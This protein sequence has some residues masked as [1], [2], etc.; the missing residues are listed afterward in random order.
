[1]QLETFADP[2]AFLAA[3][4]PHLLEAEVENNLILG[5]A[6]GT[7][8]VGGG[9]E[10]PPYFSLVR[11]SGIQGCAFSTLPSKAGITRNPSREA[12][13]LLARDLLAARPQVLDIVGPEP[14]I[15]T[16]VEIFASLRGTRI[17]RR[18]AQRIHQCHA[19]EPVTP[20]PPGRYRVA[21][22]PDV[23]LLAG[24]LQEFMTEL[25]DPQGDPQEMASSRVAAGQLFL[26][27]NGGPVSMAGWT[28]RTA[29]GV[30]VG[31]VYTPA[32]F[33]GTGYATA[34]VTALTRQLLAEDLKYCCLYTDLANPTSNAIYARIGYR[35]VC[36]AAMYTISL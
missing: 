2:T 25:A 26:W 14:T 9:S 10:P 3:A 6:H 1:M 12:L 20:V 27:D 22:A 7:R 11:S 8:M 31:F 19:V 30:R 23:G 18:V 24:W 28:G 29:R 35:P 21:A 16:F 5:I 33:R 34:C 4:E 36:D 17:L 15:G 32:R 13:T